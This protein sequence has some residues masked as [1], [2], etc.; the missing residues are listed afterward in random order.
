MFFDVDG[1]LTDGGLFYSGQGETLK[2]FHVLDGH[3]LKALQQ[4]GLRL[5]ILSGRTHPAT[6]AR[7][8]ELGFDVVIQGAERKG[9]AF[10]QVLRERGILAAECGHMGDDLPDLEIFDRVHFAAAPP[11][12]VDAVLAA[13]HW[14]SGKAGGFGA[15][16]SISVSIFA[17]L[18]A[19]SWGLNEFLRRAQLEATVVNPAGPNAIIENPR[20]TRSDAQGHAQYRLDARRILFEERADRSLVDQPVMVS[21]ASDRPA[22]VMRADRAII[23]RQQNHIDLEGNVRIERSAFDG[24]PAAK[25]FTSQ[26]TFLVREERALTDAPVLIERGAS[27]LQGKGMRLDQKTRQLEIVSDSRM[28]VPKKGQ[29]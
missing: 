21:L 11:H 20:V 16:R 12:A 10:D 26:A 27:T 14:I 28:V 22:T 3:G 5:G 9:P 24:Q 29:P 19:A 2:R 4:A 7:A 6:E 8:R 18:A 25:V 1:V 13:A 15:V 23:T 17:L